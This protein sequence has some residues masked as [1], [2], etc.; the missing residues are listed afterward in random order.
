MARDDRCRVFKN[1]GL[2][3]V[4][5]KVPRNGITSFRQNRF[6]MFVVMSV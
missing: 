1:Q 6:A 3:E 4:G 5:A 2:G